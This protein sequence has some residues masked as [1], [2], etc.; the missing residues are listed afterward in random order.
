MKDCYPTATKFEHGRWFFRHR[1]SGNWM[2]MPEG[3]LEH[4]QPDPRESPDGQSHVCA[5]YMGRVICAVLGPGT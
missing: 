3:R 4:N 2:M 1:E 5:D